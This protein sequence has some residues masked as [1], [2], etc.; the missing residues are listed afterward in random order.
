MI[1]FGPPGKVKR[2]PAPS[3]P[4]LDPY[5]TTGDWIFGTVTGSAGSVMPYAFFIPVGAAPDA[6]MKQLEVWIGG[7]DAKGDDINDVLSSELP[8][9]VSA[10]KPTYPCYVLALQIPSQDGLAGGAGWEYREALGQLVATLTAAYTIDPSR[11]HLR[12]FST[13]GI[14]CYDM[15][16]TFPTLFASITPVGASLMFQHYGL[17][18]N[19]AVSSPL[20]DHQ[21]CY[22]HFIAANPNLSVCIVVGNADS[23]YAGQSAVAARWVATGFPVT[24]VNND[25]GITTGMQRVFST[26]TVGGTHGGS[27]NT[28]HFGLGNTAYIAWRNAQVRA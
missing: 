11:R 17:V 6:A 23:F 4:P 24:S 28:A 7:V 19:H 3:V 9:V 20:G 2:R 12:G 16:S 13:G 25:S 5:P 14:Y 1:R 27:M 15:P 26:Y 22:D 18:A 21:A 10:N 8:S